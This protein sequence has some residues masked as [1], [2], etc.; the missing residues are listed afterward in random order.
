MPTRNRRHFVQRAVA[1]FAMQTHAPAELIVVDDGDD[2]VEHLCDAPQVRYIRTDGNV[3]LGAKMNL[4]IQQAS[5]EYI[6]KWDDDDW[7]HREFLETMLA[8]LLGSAN[9]DEALAAC[10]CV[11]AFMAG[12]TVL[13]RT[14]AGL[15]VG[16]TLTFTKALWKRIPFRDIGLEED[17]WFRVDTGAKIIRVNRPELYVVV[18]HGRNTWIKTRDGL[19]GHRRS[20]ASATTSVSRAGRLVL[21]RGVGVLLIAAGA[22]E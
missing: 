10:G 2:P 21:V 9:P 6:L 11:L 12:E 19:R 18:R 3:S 8:A 22:K 5:G 14:P 13:R 4:A 16:G 17:Y 1:N 7:H 20:V 15:T